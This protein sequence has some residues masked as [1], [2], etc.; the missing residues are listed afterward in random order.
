MRILVVS[1]LYPPHYLGGYELACADVAKSLRGRGHQVRVVTSMHGVAGPGE[2]DGA[3][4]FLDWR[5]D[6]RHGHWNSLRRQWRNIRVLDAEIRSFR[7][8]LVHVF[9]FSG[10]GIL[11][12]SWLHAKAGVPVVHDISD[13]W[14]PTSA[15]GMDSGRNWILCDAHLPIWRQV[16]R[17]LRRRIEEL[18]LDFSRSYT[19]SRFLTQLH[20]RAG[21]CSDELPYIHHGIPFDSIPRRRDNGTG[22]V[23]CGRL[24]R[25]KGV[26]HLLNACI[27]LAK[28]KTT[29]RLTLIGG[30]D[31]EFV[32]E[33][34]RSA[35]AAPPEL[36]TRFLG[37][38]PRDQAL[39]EVASHAVYAFPVIWDEPFSIGLVEAL[40]AGMPVVST[41]TGGSPE[42]LVHDK[43]C[44][45]VPAGDPNPLA[46]ALGRLLSDPDLARRLGDEAR[47]SVAHLDF[48]RTVDRVEAHLLAIAG[49]A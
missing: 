27:A 3:A 11:T 6:P 19:R 26:D 45:T 44:L 35:A 37:K 39:A 38:T 41:L 34:R 33:L 15:V 4:R 28:G 10:L 32:E 7:P 47:R 24:D 17:G 42:I 21:L 1:N 40:A 43:N 20:E 36:E 23:F 22:V 13:L 14:L 49:A 18:N 16:K 2:S 31:A 30:G 9:N 29:L 8:D 48:E 25:E 12:L 5:P 46:D